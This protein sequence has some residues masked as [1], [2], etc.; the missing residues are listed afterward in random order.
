MADLCSLMLRYLRC[1]VGAEVTDAAMVR[2]EVT[3]AKQLRGEVNVAIVLE[4]AIVFEL[5]RS[6]DKSQYS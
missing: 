3:T 5:R 4:E 6:E 1:L 2:E